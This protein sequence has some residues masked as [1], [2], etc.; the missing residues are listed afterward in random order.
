[1]IRSHKPIKRE[2]KTPVGLRSPC[3]A[4]FADAP[5]LPLELAAYFMQMIIQDLATFGRVGQVCKGWNAHWKALSLLPHNMIVIAKTA[6]K[7]GS[8]IFH[9]LARAGEAE[10]LEKYILF[11]QTKPEL[12]SKLSEVDANSFTP[13]LYAVRKDY[14]L[15]IEK[16]AL[17]QVDFNTPPRDHSPI[18]ISAI[19]FRAWRVVGALVKFGANLDL[20]SGGVTARQL[21]QNSNIVLPESLRSAITP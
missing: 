14:H 2:A 15:V 18:L 4:H 11:Y 21:L 8:S 3:K 20:E 7:T 10:L 19:H 9:R 16:L 12:I 13:S 1:M 17:A 5:P 6:D